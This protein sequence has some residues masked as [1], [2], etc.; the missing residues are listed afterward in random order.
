MSAEDYID[1]DN[2][3]SGDTECPGPNDFVDC[4][5]TAMRF[6]GK[7]LVVRGSDPQ[8]IFV[9]VSL[10]SKKSAVKNPGDRGSLVIPRWLADQKSLGWTSNEP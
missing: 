3:D 1:F 2:L 5:V 10:I 9:P 6:V 7:T 8:D 4:K